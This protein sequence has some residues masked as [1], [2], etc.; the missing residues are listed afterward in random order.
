M[1]RPPFPLALIQSLEPSEENLLNMLCEQL[2][3]DAIMRIARADYGYGAEANFADL[4]QFVRERVF[5]SQMTFGTHEVLQLTRWLRA[6]TKEEVLMRSYACV[7]LL[8]LKPE[9]QCDESAESSSLI[10]LV[11]GAIRLPELRRPALQFVAWKVLKLYE[12]ELAYCRED[13]D[14]ES[15]AY[16]ESYSLFALLLLMIANDAPTGNVQTIY[17]TLTGNRQTDE[18]KSAAVEYLLQESGVQESMWRELT[19][20]LLNF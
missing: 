19:G 3:D 12:Q 14:D 18:E 9:T 2:S 4:K 20:Q 11:D 1:T 15:E 16:I 13:G 7:L 8:N 17:N 10:G 6:E 5:P